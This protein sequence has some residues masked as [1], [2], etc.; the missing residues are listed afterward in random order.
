MSKFTEW[1]TL[2][3]LLGN[4]RK[5]EMLFRLS[6]LRACPTVTKGPEMKA[7]V[8]RSILLLCALPFLSGCLLVGAANYATHDVE[9]EALRSDHERGVSSTA[10]NQSKCDRIDREQLEEARRIVQEAEGKNGQ[11]P[12]PTV[13]VSR[14]RIEQ[15]SIR[16]ERQVRNYILRYHAYL[17]TDLSRG[18][19]EYLSNLYTMLRLPDNVETLKRLR[20]LAARNQEALSFAEGVLSQYPV[21][22]PA[23][24]SQGQKTNRNSR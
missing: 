17:I 7:I 5:V 24:P 4:R 3:L 19:G 13:T 15:E 16:P 10:W 21:D 12:P 2:I 22:D 23:A 11:Q 14:T 18:Q 8:G 9:C 1:L 6:I 20:S